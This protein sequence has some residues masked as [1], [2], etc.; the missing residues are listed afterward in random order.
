MSLEI[1][2]SIVLSYLIGSIPTAY[3]LGR[4]FKGVDIRK[5]GSGNVG[6]TNAFRV[7]GKKIGITVLIFD[8]FKGLFVV[9]L[10]GDYLVS[11]LSFNPS[12]ARIILGLTAVA[13]HIWTVFLKF[14]GGKG[15][16]T[17]LGVFLGLA[18]RIEGLGWTVFLV[19]LSWLVI[20]LFFRIVS[21]ASVITAFGFP[22]YTYL[23]CKEKEVFFFSL[24]FSLL[25]LLRHKEN[26]KRLISREEK[27]LF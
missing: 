25:I 11:K 7:L 22:I 24:I 21:L 10:L 4:L 27:P 19:I 8:I 15:V 9:L 2:R 6:A 20:F 17:S 13:G 14:K 26:I 12:L 16:A 5:F 3:I 1:L 18:L 23:F